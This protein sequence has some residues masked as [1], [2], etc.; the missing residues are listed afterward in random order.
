M[1]RW[2]PCC[3]QMRNAIEDAE[4]PITYIPKLREVGIDVLDGGTSFIVLRF[5]PWSG[6]KLPESL[7]DRWFDELEAR[8]IDPHEGPIPPEFQTEQWYEQSRD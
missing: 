5:C 8:G 7:R 4:I 6:H 2:T 1:S 3:D